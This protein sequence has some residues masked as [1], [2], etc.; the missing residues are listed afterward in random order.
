MDFKYAIIEL[1][2][3]STVHVS[4]LSMISIRELSDVSSHA[5]ASFK[6][7]GPVS[8]A[9]T[10]SCASMTRSFSAASGSSALF[11]E[12]L[13]CGVKPSACPTA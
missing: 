3:G 12:G 4:W 8:V 11:G 10:L 5:D 1:E 7:L 6:S 9:L 13:F 2:S